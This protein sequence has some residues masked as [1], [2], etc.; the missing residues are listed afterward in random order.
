MGSDE[1]EE[2]E[3]DELWSESESF[4]TCDTCLV[5]LLHDV[6][7]SVGMTHVGGNWPSDGGGGSFVPQCG[8]CNIYCVCTDDKLLYARYVVV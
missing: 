6:S 3:S 5:G 2:E 1:S 8:R 4:G 7:F